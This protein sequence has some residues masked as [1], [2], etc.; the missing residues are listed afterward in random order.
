M[1]QA[2]FALFE[3]QTD[4]RRRACDRAVVDRRSE[5]IRRGGDLVFQLSHFVGDIVDRQHML[6]SQTTSIARVIDLW[7]EASLRS[8]AA[9]DS[10]LVKGAVRRGSSRFIHNAEMWNYL[11]VRERPP[12]HE[13]LIGDIFEIWPPVGYDAALLTTEGILSVLRG[14]HGTGFDF[15]QPQY[16]A[17]SL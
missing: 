13:R 7:A 1:R 2:V 17:E 6:V 11:E 4:H 5:F 14:V 3:L 8:F 15:N 9:A 16:L 10:K 12:Q